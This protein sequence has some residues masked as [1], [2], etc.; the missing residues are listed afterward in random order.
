MIIA[1]VYLVFC[2]AMQTLLQVVSLQRCAKL[3]D[4]MF[5]IGLQMHSEVAHL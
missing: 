4:E 2:D 1:D 3:P 5:F